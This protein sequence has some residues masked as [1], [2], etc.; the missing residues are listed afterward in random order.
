MSA[1]R[2]F[3]PELMLLVERVQY[4]PELARK[5]LLEIAEYLAHGKALPV[6]VSEWLATA[7]TEAL[8]H[9]ERY[10]HEN[11]PE[12]DEGQALLTT[13]GLRS[14]SRRKAA[15]EY[16]I[17]EYMLGYMEQ[18]DTSQREA[19]KVASKHFKIGQ[20][21]AHR[22]FKNINGLLIKAGLL[23]AKPKI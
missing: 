3:D 4:S 13:L 14:N 5:A 7:I 9:P 16:E 6:G 22:Y 11:D 23:Q 2:D 18:H 12:C 8:L 21:T 17:Y 19:A 15:N 10:T 20:S 1:P